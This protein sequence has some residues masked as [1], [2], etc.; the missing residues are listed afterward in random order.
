MDWSKYRLDKLIYLAA[1][2]IPGFTALLIFELNRPGAFDW[3]F[4]LGF[5]GYRTKL[6]LIMLVA[7]VIGHTL[8]SLLGAVLGAMG[9]AFGGVA[10]Y[11]PPNFHETAPWRDSTWRRP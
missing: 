2:V 5:L 1:G 6:G 7:F 8:T 10:G 4:Q 9:G 3:F 11:L